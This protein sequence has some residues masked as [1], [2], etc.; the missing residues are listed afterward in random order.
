[1]RNKSLRLFPYD[2]DQ[3]AL[4]PPPFKFA[5]EDS[6]PRSEVELAA[7]DSNDDFAVHNL[8][9]VMG[10]TIIL[11]S[12]VV[13]IAADW[14]IWGEFFE[15]AFVVFVQSALVVVYEDAGCYVH[16][17]DE[18]QSLAD[19]ALRNDIL[20]LWCYVNEV[21]SRWEVESQAFSYGSSLHFP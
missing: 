17:V 14:F 5:V 9:L 15:S 1:M 19:T 13:F 3:N 10:I 7:C 11:A 2:L 20:H 16:G 6:L 4:G 21:H 8:S 18:A 12:A